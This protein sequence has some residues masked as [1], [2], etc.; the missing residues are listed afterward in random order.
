MVMCGVPQGSTLGPLLFI[1]YIND[2]LSYIQNV[3]VTLY[4]DDTA[5]TVVGQKPEEVSG[6]MSRAADKFLEYCNMNNLE[7][8]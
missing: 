5:F 2:V 7:F 4:A 1:A 6:I 8:R 3:S